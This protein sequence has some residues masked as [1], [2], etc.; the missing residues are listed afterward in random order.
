VLGHV[1][2]A[3]TE[4]PLGELLG[5]QVGELVDGVVHQTLTGGVA[6]GNQAQVQLE[7]SE[8]MHFLSGS[9][10]TAVGDDEIIEQAAVIRCLLLR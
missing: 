2:G 6:L 5:A 9:V 4:V 3:E 10:V 8:G 7:A 1:A